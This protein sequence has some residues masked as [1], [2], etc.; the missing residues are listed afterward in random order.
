VNTIPG[1]APSSDDTNSMVA[2]CDA[3]IHT[4]QHIGPKH[5]AAP[6]PDEATL[7]DMLRAAAAAP[8]HERLRPW[9]MM[10]LGASARD[11]LAQAFA[12]ALLERDPQALPQQLQDARDKAYRGPVLILA[13]ADLRA[14]NDDVP[15]V[16][17]L[18]TLG[19]ALQNLMLAAHVRGFGTGLS[20]GRALRSRALREA[21]GVRAGEHAVCFVTLGTPARRK[22]IGPRPGVDDIAHWI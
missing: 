16:E 15:D 3:L 18:V 5:L 21:F 6:G 20:S 11:A 9:R 4:R 7:R 13:I 19:C 14:D 17:R 12:D 2:L 8:D 10:V 1:V 22:A